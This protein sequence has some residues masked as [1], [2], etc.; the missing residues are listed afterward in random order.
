LQLADFIAVRADGGF[1]LRAT[2]NEAG[3]GDQGLK[4]FDPLGLE[5]GRQGGNAGALAGLN[6]CLP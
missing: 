4:R 6:P 1:P 5:G 3:I 2:I